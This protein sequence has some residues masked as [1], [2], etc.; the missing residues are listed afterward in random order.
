ME[1]SAGINVK[2]PF[3][4]IMP[5][6]GLLNLD[7]KGVWQY[8]ELL[9]FLV[10]RD[11]MV[12]YKQT[13][14]G[15]AW[16]ILQPLITMVIFTVI[17]GNL[18]KI[19]SEG[20]PYPVFAFAALLPWSYFS[21]A[22]TRNSSSVVSSSNLV[23]KVYFPRLLIPIAASVAPIVDLFFSFLILLVLMAWYQITPTWGLLAL[24]FF[25]GLCVMTALAVGL[26]SS[27]LNVR[28]RDV[29]H[30]IPFLIQVWMYASPVA[31]PASMVPEKW[32]LLYSLN[33]M[34][35]VIEGFRWALLG[36]ESPDFLIMAVS[37]VV[38]LITLIGGVIYFK[39]SEETFADVI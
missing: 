32:R 5:R 31:Y 7:L 37:L 10:W 12:R 1:S 35:G 30:V 23:T 33:P 36:K 18:A 9:Y 27:A 21:Q 17:F 11:V 26:W 22:L 29:G 16:A 39:K 20:I 4:V 15:V 2:E 3:I 14:I 24:P 25:L 34:V 38:V 8:R 28:Y 19:P 6:K 13:A